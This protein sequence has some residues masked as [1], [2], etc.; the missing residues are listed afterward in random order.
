M[1]SSLEADVQAR[2][3][4]KRIALVDPTPRPELIAALEKDGYVV[5][6]YTHPLDALEKIVAR[7]VKIALIAP[8]L[9]WMSGSALAR[10]L[11]ESYRI[12]EVIVLEKTS[13]DSQILNRVRS[14]APLA[15]E[16]PKTKT[17]PR[18]TAQ[19]AGRVARTSAS[20]RRIIVRPARTS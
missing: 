11:K 17:K 2:I 10:S 7:A 18:L 9:P 19:A 1:F 16:A 4:E 5:D 13:T 12:G 15:K 14:G 20:G 3:S 8:E 6:T